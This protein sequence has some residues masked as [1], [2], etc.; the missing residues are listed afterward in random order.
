MSELTVYLRDEGTGVLQKLW[1]IEGE[2]ES[3]WLLA[4]LPEQTKRVVRTGQPAQSGGQYL[5]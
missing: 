4:K 1:S 5:A 3:A 2:Q